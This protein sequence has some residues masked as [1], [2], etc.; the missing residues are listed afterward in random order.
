MGALTNGQPINPPYA[1]HIGISYTFNPFD[2]VPVQRVDWDYRSN[3][4]EPTSESS[5]QTPREFRFSVGVR[6]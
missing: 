1:V 2:T 5:F 3:F 6:F 4:G